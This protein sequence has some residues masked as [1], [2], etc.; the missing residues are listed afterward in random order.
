MV[1]LFVYLFVKVYIHTS[2]M[3]VIRRLSSFT[4][5][6]SRPQGPSVYYFRH[7]RVPESEDSIQ[8][9]YFWNYYLEPDIQN[10]SY[11][12]SNRQEHDMN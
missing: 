9:P 6:C 11:Y 1:Y 4:G 2:T 8:G 7:E 10:T 12:S 5:G 3:T